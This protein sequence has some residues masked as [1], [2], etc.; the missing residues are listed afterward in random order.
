MHLFTDPMSIM[1][2]KLFLAAILG[3]LVGTER[4]IAG[5]QAGSRT[6]S[7]V[8]LGSC[9]FV[10]IG[11][12]VNNAYTGVVDFQPTLM[13][14]AIITGVG[15]IGAGLI[16]IH[17]DAPRG[18]TTAAGL[19]VSAAVGVAVGFGMYSIAVFT[20]VLTL[21]IFTGLWFLENSF[22]HW[23]VEHEPHFGSNNN[24]QPP[25]IP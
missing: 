20:T 11:S 10:L 14:S 21:I 5:K 4:A 18:I 17:G 25:Q 23:F 24:S 7:L 16:V 13:A 22:K 19:W 3:V 12:F 2:G 1:F 8:A 6:F 15:F 9:L